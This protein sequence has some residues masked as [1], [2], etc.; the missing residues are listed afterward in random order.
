MEKIKEKRM[1]ME[2]L[3]SQKIPQTMTWYTELEL[4]LLPELARWPAREAAAH[5]D[6]EGEAARER[7]CGRRR[8][9]RGARGAAGEAAQA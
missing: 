4:E 7:P 1:T 8:R 2:R 5:A 3:P 9:A 6:G